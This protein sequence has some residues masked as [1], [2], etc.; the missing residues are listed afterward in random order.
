ML[1]L[2]WSK[3]NT[4]ALL[5]GMENCTAT[6]EI[7]MMVTRKLG[8][9]LPNDPAI[10]LLGIYPRDEYSYLKG[11]S[12]NMFIAALFVIARTWKQA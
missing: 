7:N 10:P 8:I 12:S 6:L 1:E 4:P 11:I 3:D 5:V 9:N 2:M